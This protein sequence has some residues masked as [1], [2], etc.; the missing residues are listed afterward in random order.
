MRVGDGD[1]RESGKLFREKLDAVVDEKT[2]IDLRRL[3]G[4]TSF[5]KMFGLFADAGND[6]VERSTNTFFISRQR[7]LL[8]QL[9]QL[10]AP[11]L[12]GL[13]RRNVVHLRRERRVF[14]RIDERPPVVEASPVLEF[15]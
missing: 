9:H 10:C 3:S 11:A 2:S 15:V 8:L 6:G 7:D 1:S 5:Q 4:Q 13:A 12:R 14:R